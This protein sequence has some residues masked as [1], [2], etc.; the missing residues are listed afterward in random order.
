MTRRP[1]ASLALLGMLSACDVTLPWSSSPGSAGGGGGGTPGAFTLSTSTV[2]FSAFRGAAAPPSRTVTATITGTGVSFFAAGFAPGSTPPAWLAVNARQAGSGF[3]VDLTVLT[4]DLPP[5]SRSATVKVQTQD[6]GGQP[7]VTKDVAVTYTVEAGIAVTSAPRTFTFVYGD[8][9]LLEL[10]PVSVTAAGKTWSAASDAAWLQV[11]AGNRAGNGTL[12]VLVD[13]TT[14][15]V[16]QHVGRLTVT[17]AA[18]PADSASLVFDVTVQ[19]PVLAVTQA[20]VML[21]GD[22]G[23]SAPTATLAFS[24]SAGA[25]IHPYTI[26]PTTTSGGAWLAASAASGD[27]GAAGAE[28]TLTG[29]RAVS[30]SGTFAGQVRVS[31][32]VKD[33]VLTKDVP[34]TLNLE[35]HRIAAAAGGVG[36]S[37]TPGRSVLTRTL[38]VSDTLGRTDVPWVASADQPWL[39]VTPSGQTGQGLTL[40][41]DPSGLVTETTHFATVTVSSPD[42][43]V[44]GVDTIRVGLY[45]T[46]TA[47]A[48]VHQPATASLVAASPVEPVV[49]LAE[50][51]TT[52]V[53]ARNV[54]TGEVVRTFPDVVASAGSLA[55]GPDGR[56][57][58]VYDRQLRVTEVDA[59][60]GGDPRH[61][62]SADADPGYP[63]GLAVF[64][65]S[66]RT[67]L[68]TPSSRVHDVESGAELPEDSRFPAARYS[69]SLFVTGDG[70]LAVTDWGGVHALARTAL[71]GGR[72][73]ATSLFSTGT[74]SGRDGQACIRADGAAVY[75]ASG[76]RYEFPGTSL[77]TRLPLHVL[78]GE[79][80][81]NAMVCPWNGLVIGGADA[82][83]AYD[84]VWIYDSTGTEL[85]RT[86][87]SS[88]TVGYRSLLDRGLAVSADGS[89][90]VSLSTSSGGRQVTFQS[91]PA[92]P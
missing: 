52:T 8:V 61:F 33:L 54:F 36:F 49:F 88:S 5:G 21:G 24:V 50:Y 76:G 74:V 72:F 65:A 87:S 81:P 73:T 77:V 90:L 32:T 30:G 4:T 66:G 53:T 84:D 16:G 18:D 48:A 44:E 47:P 37:S 20:A 80:Y 46:V 71:G 91:L 13:A 35:E 62:A 28:V 63:G 68:V 11:P 89:R 70:T 51:A 86:S 29:D 92:P 2:V 40:T 26:T 34:V 19:A 69:R 45:V 75:T 7:L 60:T 59:V 57:L 64:R 23:R 85:D 79:P 78:P 43:T 58:Y 1:L 56:R 55:V 38:T 9:D 41:A 6:A 67:L 31:V 42:P 27:V 83:Y 17:N 39:T 3:A 14:L 25:A 10:L 82:Y 12:D 22:D 15:A